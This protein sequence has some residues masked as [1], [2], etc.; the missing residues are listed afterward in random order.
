MEMMRT[1]YRGA[2]RT[3]MS[4]ANPALSD[5]EVR[6]RVTAAVAHCQ[7]DV[8]VARMGA[9]IADDSLEQALAVGDRLWI[10]EHGTNPWFT[11]DIAR[12]TRDLLP[13]A[14]VLE[15]EDGPVSRPDI[16]AGYVRSLTAARAPTGR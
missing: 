14:H 10:L 6:E 11:I 8:A 5:E 15:V 1:D 9:W 12:V 13:E 16:A 4:T 3:M 7:Q 2:I